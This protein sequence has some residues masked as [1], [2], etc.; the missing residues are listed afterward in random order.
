MATVK[1][2][3]GKLQEANAA[4]WRRP[5][6]AEGPASHFIASDVGALDPCL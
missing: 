5:P 4:R 3:F 6:R 1:V 2:N